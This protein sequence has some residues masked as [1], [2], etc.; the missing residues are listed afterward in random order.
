MVKR[1]RTGKREA[2]MLV[3]KQELEQ[4]APDGAGAP[5]RAG[6]P[7]RP[8]SQ[9]AEDA[10]L[11]AT[12]LILAEEGYG[13]LTTSKIAAR[14]RASKSTIYRRWPSKE[15]LVLA[16]FDRSPPLCPRDSGDLAADLLD[17]VQQFVRLLRETPLGGA[18][19]ALAAERAH[20]PSLAAAFDPWLTRRRQPTR[21]ILE[22]AVAR[23]ELPPDLDLELALDLIW[24]PLMLRLVFPQSAVTPDALA[25]LLR[26][27]LRGL[28]ARMDDARA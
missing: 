14:A 23:S 1:G 24:G 21:Q 19:A 18:L 28:G 20:N 16:A 3:Q 26:A 17:I 22:R 12:M 13:E 8:R 9:E 4:P 27:A 6:Q 2:A 15:H 25:D 5:E 7:G 11:E 10:I